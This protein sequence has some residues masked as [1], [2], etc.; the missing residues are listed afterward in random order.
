MGFDRLHSV[1][2]TGHR[3]YAGEAQEALYVLIRT[4]AE[5][6]A[7]TFLSGMAR[8]FDLSAAEAVLALRDAGLAIRLVAVV[9]FASQANR[10][11]AE[12]RDRFRRVLATAD[13]VILLA[14]DYF[15]GCY[16]QRNDFLVEHAA[17]LV[18]WYDGSRGGTRYTFLKAM[19]CGLTLHNLS[20]KI[21]P[22][23]TLFP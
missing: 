1:A 5:Q 7:T 4:L 10:F 11:S 23:P 8:G 9:P 6:G 18:A 13:E 2:F 22:D 12:D 15:R 20:P 19:K 14:S 16:Q 17:T 21:L 3:T